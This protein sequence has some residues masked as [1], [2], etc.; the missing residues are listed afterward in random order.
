MSTS[1]S[2]DEM[3]TV[4][5]VLG[6]SC[7]QAGFAGSDAP[8]YVEAS[9]VGI[10]K[11]TVEPVMV[12]MTMDRRYYGDCALQNS[13]IVDLTYPIHRGAVT[14]WDH[15]ETLITGVFK[16]YLRVDTDECNLLVTEP[17]LN[18]RENREK[19]S[20][21]F[22]E[23]YNVPRMRIETDGVLSLYSVGTTTGVS[24]SSGGGVTSVIPVY[25]GYA[26]QN[27]IKRLDIGGNDVTEYL[28]RLL[29]EGGYCFRTSTDREI[30]RSI[31]ESLAYVSCNFNQD[32]AMYYTQ[33]LPEMEKTYELPD[34]N[35]ITISDQLFRCTECLFQPLAQLGREHVGIHQLV[36]S[37]IK[38]CDI[39]VRKDLYS[40][41]ILTGG[42]TMFP[43]FS[44]RIQKEI[45]NLAPPKSKVRMISPPE[46]KYSV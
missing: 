14:N 34:G 12:G 4:V 10:Q 33:W 45:T 37:S 8:R 43:G 32:M 36:Y 5:M 39:D 31:K 44:E 13:A 9:V 21:I 6:S 11:Q 16:N 7:I 29:T 1:S 18:P 26:I 19:L 42:N 24:V 40:N 17:P 38:G 23:T 35:V 22:F 25:E 2:S 28:T 15:F 3:S 20:Q 30:V 46:R 41:I 27:A